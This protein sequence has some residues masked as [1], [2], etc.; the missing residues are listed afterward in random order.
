MRLINIG[1]PKPH[2]ALILLGLGVGGLGEGATTAQLS[3]LPARLTAL[4]CHQASLTNL[5]SR[6]EL[7]LHDDD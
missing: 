3:L 4:V 1:N 6:K 5:V 7:V 2:L